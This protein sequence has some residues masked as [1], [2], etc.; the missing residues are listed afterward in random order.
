MSDAAA[1]VAFLDAMLDADEAAA[2]ESYYEGQR[3]ITEEEGVYRY[4]DDE[5]VHSADR[6]ADARHI[7][8]HDPARVLREVEAKRKIVTRYE[9]AAAI[10]PSIAA[11]TRGQDDGYREACLDAVQDLT[12]VYAGE[13]GYGP[14]WAPA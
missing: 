1:M 12:A 9:R 14:A 3:W 6:K 7:A 8:R 2:R 11:F 5:L 13:P 4:P 10:P